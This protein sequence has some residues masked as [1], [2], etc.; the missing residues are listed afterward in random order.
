M[1]LL[2]SLYRND[3]RNF[4]L[5]GTTMESGLGRSEADWKRQISWCCNTHMNGN[6][7]R[8]LCVKLS[9]LQTRKPSCFSFYLYLFCF[10][11]YKIREQEGGK[12][13]AEG[14]DYAVGKDVR[15][16]VEGM[17]V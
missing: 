6:S 11:F 8:K 16:E 13:S 12:G 17:R 7:T 4:K 15:R 1:R 2:C 9:L 5:A 3:Y 14:V 10:F